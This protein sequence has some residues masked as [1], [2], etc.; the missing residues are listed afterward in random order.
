MSETLLYAP[1]R[2]LYLR[3]LAQMV[4]FVALLSASW[5]RG[6][7]A[8]G[9]PGL[10]HSGF[11]DM[12][13]TAYGLALDKN[14]LSL[15]ATPTLEDSIASDES[16][17]LRQRNLSLGRDTPSRE[18][19]SAIAYATQQGSF[20]MMTAGSDRASQ[21]GY[22]A[23]YATDYSISVGSS[24]RDDGISSFSNRAGSD[25]RLH[26]VW[27]PAA[28]FILRYL[29]IDMATRMASLWQLLTLLVLL[30]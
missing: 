13:S 22:P 23:R 15:A 17:F 30:R 26:H 11:S 3:A 7:K 6:P 14:S 2:M 1:S 20:V 9:Q 25:R 12:F 19:A 4:S 21:P 5:V 27:H 28:E 24:D 8:R 10:F 16:A 29:T 18:L